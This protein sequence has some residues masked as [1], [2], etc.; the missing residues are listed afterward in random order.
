MPAFQEFQRIAPDEFVIPFFCSN[1][2]ELL[3]RL[4][5]VLEGE[6]IE[7]W[8]EPLQLLEGES[9]SLHGDITLSD[10]LRLSTTFS[11][12]SGKHPTTR[13]CIDLLKEVLTHRNIKTLFDIGTGSGIL[14]LFALSLGVEKVLAADIDFNSCKEALMNVVNN[15]YQ[16]KIIIVQ[17]NHLVGKRNSF[18]LITAN[19][20]KDTIIKMLPEFPLLLKK[21]GLGI[22]SGLTEEQL[23]H[24]DFQSFGLLLQL[25]KTE[26]GWAAGL[27]QKLG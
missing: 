6:I 23:G 9:K 10:S 7:T 11:F 17:A 18:D 12:G 26:S 13:L 5:D 21:E 15:S 8:V 1:I 20:L 14:A 16:E 27:V 24:I 22:I 2:N 3:T 19:L 4:Q 25:L